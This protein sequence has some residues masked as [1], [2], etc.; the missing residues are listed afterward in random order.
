MRRPAISALGVAAALTAA[1]CSGSHSQVKAD[2]TTLVPVDTTITEP[3]PGDGCNFT[4]TPSKVGGWA[5]LADVFV[6]APIADATSVYAGANSASGPGGCV[7]ALDSATGNLK[8]QNERPITPQSLPLLAGKMVVASV[9]EGGNVALIGLDAE[10][11]QRRWRISVAGGLSAPPMLAGDLVYVPGG[12]SLLAVNPATGRLRW[13]ID[14]KPLAVAAGPAGVFAT[15]ADEDTTTAV[16]PKTGKLKWSTPLGT[17]SAVV[18]V[19]TA[20]VAVLEN[21]P[22]DL[23][24]LDAVTG[25]QLWDTNMPG[26]DNSTIAVAGEE[27]YL[28]TDDGK[29]YRMDAKTGRIA[30]SKA[31]GLTLGPAPVVVND[32]VLFA[33]TSPD[34]AIAALDRTTGNER[35]RA[36]TSG[37]PITSELLRVGDDVVVGTQRGVLCRFTIDG[38]RRTCNELIG[39][40]VGSINRMPAAGAGRVYTRVGN[41]TI[42]A[43]P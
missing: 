15:F 11:G 18:K 25:R 17:R 30:W 43:S 5:V 40:A 22:N 21:A 28:S 33:S 3:P 29:G 31:L 1:S 13:R 6:T 37:G 4:S 12:A 10:T 24:G 26:S 9:T 8:W 39:E 2:R 41:Q 38:I 35:F 16:D 42:A 36:P 14:R 23:Y 19:V 32:T 20:G 34:T 7:F 27:L